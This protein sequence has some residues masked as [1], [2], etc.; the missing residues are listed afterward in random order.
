MFMGTDAASAL[1]ECLAPFLNAL[2]ESLPPLVGCTCISNNADTTT[3][4]DPLS[5]GTT[6]SCASALKAELNSADLD[7]HTDSYASASHHNAIEVLIKWAEKLD[8]RS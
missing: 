4:N 8:E 3:Q 7:S 5:T 1:Y 6:G 2:K